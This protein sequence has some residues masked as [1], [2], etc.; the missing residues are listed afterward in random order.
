MRGAF[1][2][3]ASAIDL[4]ASECSEIAVG[5]IPFN[6][7]PRGPQQQGY[8]IYTQARAL[9]VAGMLDLTRSPRT[10][11]VW[12]EVTSR[13][14]LRCTYC[15]LSQDDIP[16]VDLDLRNID[17]FIAGLKS[18]GATE[19]IFNGRGENTFLA[20]WQDVVHKAL[21]IGLKVTTVTNLALSY[22][23]EEIKVLS[24]L[25]SITVSVDTTDPAIFR[26]IR[27]K[28]DIKLVLTNI[29]RIR[30]AA[31]AH[32]RRPPDIVWNMIV[33]DQS[34]LDLARSVSEGIAAGVDQFHLSI[35]GEKP[36]LPD[37]LNARQIDR[38]SPQ[39]LSSGFEQIR[40]AHALAL[41]NRRQMTMAP[42]LNELLTELGAKHRIEPHPKM[43]VYG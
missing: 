25:T 15:H 30:A 42:A 2:A 6:D 3:G 37:A 20:G 26:A 43:S 32:D 5:S 13:C 9:Y 34:M 36:E 16:E 31:F 12:L 29:L 11:K 18:R 27:R 10:E 14:N 38:L 33:H 22:S 21:A 8:R 39:A 24:R 19:L 41:A 23:E 4:V 28:A 17:R 40:R 7:L 35:L 1:G